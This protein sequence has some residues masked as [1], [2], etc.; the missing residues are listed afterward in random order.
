MRRQD[1]SSSRKASH[2]EVMAKRSSL[3][4]QHPWITQKPKNKGTG[5]GGKTET[6][7]SLN[8]TRST[9]RNSGPSVSDIQKIDKLK[10]LQERRNQYFQNKQTE[11]LYQSE[12]QQFF[13][14]QNIPSAPPKL[15]QQSSIATNPPTTGHLDPHTDQLLQQLT[16]KLTNHIQE[17]LKKQHLNSELQQ[18]EVCDTILSRIDDFVSRELSSFCCPICYEI[19]APP[20]RLPMLLFPCGHT[21]C[22]LCLEQ[23]IQ[24]RAVSAS[25]MTTS[26]GGRSCP[27]CR[28]T[29]ES[30]AI[31]QSL[32]ELVDQF[33]AQKG[34][35]ENRKGKME[36]IFVS[37]VYDFFHA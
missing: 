20:N 12:K 5:G 32:K 31:N 17:N 24:R 8:V 34:K 11:E 33:L 18:S 1:E 4:S 25:T 19:M 22:Q 2:R 28:E 6:S 30:R 7:G 35:I 26:G 13:S 21:F 36:D 9:T 10:M 15:T 3:S 23:H 16:Y 37:Q 14:N 29:I 27:Y